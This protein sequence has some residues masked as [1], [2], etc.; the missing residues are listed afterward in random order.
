M[1]EYTLADDGKRAVM[2]WLSSVISDDAVNDAAANDAGQQEN[3]ISDGSYTIATVCYHLEDGSEKYRRYPVSREQ[4]QAFSSVY[5]TVEY[6]EKAYPDSCGKY[7]R[8]PLYMGRR[9]DGDRSE[10]DGG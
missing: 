3:G 1:K 10:A 2:A 6:K 4:F 5:D 7:G 9:S 8:R